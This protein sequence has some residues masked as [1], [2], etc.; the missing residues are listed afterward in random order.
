MKHE[1]QDI[2]MKKKKSRISKWPINIEK[3]A[4]LDQTPGDYKT[5]PQ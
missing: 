3:H 1:N 5:K 2:K 4:Q